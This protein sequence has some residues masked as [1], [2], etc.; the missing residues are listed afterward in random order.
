MWTVFVMFYRAGA[1]KD[2]C[3]AETKGNK[4][5]R[6]E[7]LQTHSIMFTFQLLRPELL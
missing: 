7:K 4:Q 3:A 2:I 5:T 6:V 1:N